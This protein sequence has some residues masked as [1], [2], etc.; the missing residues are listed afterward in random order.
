MIKTAVLLTVFN[1]R[2]VTLKGLRALYA[3]IE[4]LQKERQKIGYQFDVYMTDD[5]CTDGTSDAVKNEFPEVH[6]LQGDGNLYWCGGMLKAWIYAIN[7]G[8]SY[9]GFLWF[10]DDDN[11]Y[12]D[13]LVKLFRICECSNG[14]AII[15][16]AFCDDEGNT[17][18]G[19]W[20]RNS[21]ISPNGKNQKVEIINGNLVYIPASIQKK[22]GLLNKTFRHSYADWE[23]GFRAKKYGYELLLTPSF[24]GVCN[25]HDNTNKCFLATVPFRERIADLYTPTSICP[26]DLVFYEFNCRGIYRA[27]RA[28][29]AVHLRCFFPQLWLKK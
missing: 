16:G 25:R 15:S 12:N 28:Y 29:V 8:I 22:V 24:V 23:Y 6:I 4:Y 10:N 17:S 19:G 3:A 7:T 20:I 5:G 14:S 2:E 21:L 11:L 13:A 27:F 1:R 9:D 26:K 18:Y